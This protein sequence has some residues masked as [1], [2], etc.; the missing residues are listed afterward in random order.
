MAAAKTARRQADEAEAK[1]KRELAQREKKVEE[2]ELRLE[3]Y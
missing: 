3:V 2:K 1:K